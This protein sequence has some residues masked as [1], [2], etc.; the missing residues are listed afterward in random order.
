MK[1]TRE[2]MRATVNIWKG[3]KK[4]MNDENMT[5]VINALADKIRMLEWD[6]KMLQE[7]IE[8]LLSMI[9]EEKREEITPF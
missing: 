7:R 2:T 1:L 6:K 8:K 5:I 4:T 3:R 9:P